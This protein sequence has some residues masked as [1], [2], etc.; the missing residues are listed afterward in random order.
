MKN[1]G[2]CYLFEKYE[3]VDPFDN[4]KGCRPLEKVRVLRPLWPLKKY[5][6]DLLTLVALCKFR[7]GVL[8]IMALEI[9]GGGLAFENFGSGHDPF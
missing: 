8:T 7:G 2:T 6:G 1:L 4:L 9:F 3:V 5:R